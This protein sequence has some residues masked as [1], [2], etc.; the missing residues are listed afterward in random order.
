MS[1]SVSQ[2]VDF[3][4]EEGEESEVK[5]QRSEGLGRMGRMG[6]VGLVGRVWEW[7]MEDDKWQKKASGRGYFGVRNWR[8]SSRNLRNCSRWGSVRM[9]EISDWAFDMMP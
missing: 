3:W 7:Q 6:L 2:R 4:G 5:G 1:E 9:A 8:W